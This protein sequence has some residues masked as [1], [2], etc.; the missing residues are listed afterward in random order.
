LLK[1]FFVS[2][3]SWGIDHSWIQRWFRFLNIQLKI[4]ELSCP[5]KWKVYNNSQKSNLKL[6]GRLSNC[7]QTAPLK[8]CKCFMSIKTPKRFYWK[9]FKTFS[10]HHI[11]INVFRR[12][13]KNIQCTFTLYL[14]QGT[15]KW[16]FT[17]ICFPFFTILSLSKYNYFM[18]IENKHLK[19]QYCG[20]I[21]LIRTWNHCKG[22]WQKFLRHS[23]AVSPST[24]HSDFRTV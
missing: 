13:T 12:S 14:A 9:P 21:M 17:H 10:E 19:S 7:F 6:S 16:T 22:G 11:S 24:P 3:S 4:R 15:V 8:H 23:D 1:S 2:V 20:S 18:V 5:M